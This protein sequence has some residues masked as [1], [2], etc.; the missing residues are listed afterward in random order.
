MKKF[1]SILLVAIMTLSFATVA[2]AE[3]ETEAKKYTVYFVYDT[4]DGE[5]TDVFEVAYG[6]DLDEVAPKVESYVHP[7]DNTQLVKFD[8][9]KTDNYASLKGQELYNLPAFVEKDG[10]VDGIR[11][12]A[13]NKFVPNDFKNQTEDKIEDILGNIGL[14]ETNPLEGMGDF[15]NTVVELVKKWFTLFM[16]YIRSFI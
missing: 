11:F 1:I 14:P 4:K 5:K 7:S 10:D 2:F 12:E 9:W 6:T 15:F 13:V 3:G 8:H 16:F